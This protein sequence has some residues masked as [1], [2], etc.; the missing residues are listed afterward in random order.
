MRLLTAGDQVAIGQSTPFSPAGL[1]VLATSTSATAAIF[2][3]GGGTSAN[4]F[5]VQRADGNSFLSVSATGS[6]ILSQGLLHV[7]TTTG[8]STIQAN[9]QI[10]TNLGITQNLAVTENF[11]ALGSSLNLGN[12]AA[13]AFNVN[14]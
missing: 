14:A 9:L 3:S 1:S 5:D 13:D 10:G 7:G 8:T 12:N 2:R 6:A 11:S 4:I